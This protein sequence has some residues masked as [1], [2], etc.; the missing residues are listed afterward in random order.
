MPF[1]GYQII[2]KDVKKITSNPVSGKMINLK[3]EF[4]DSLQ[5][6]FA[7]VLEKRYCLL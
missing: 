2:F 7:F 6:N 4:R 1:A 5:Y 3:K